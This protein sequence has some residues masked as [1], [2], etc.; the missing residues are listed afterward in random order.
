LGHPVYCRRATFALSQSGTEVR[1]YHPPRNLLEFYMR[2]GAF[3]GNLVAVICIGRNFATKI[4]SN[5]QLQC[6]HVLMIVGPTVLSLLLSNEHAL[7]QVLIIKVISIRALMFFNSKSE[8]GKCI[9]ARNRQYVRHQLKHTLRNLRP[10][11]LKTVCMHFSPAL[12]C[13]CTLQY[14]L[15]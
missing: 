8:V 11:A 12:A 4:E 9:T 6:A 10:H 1:G 7:T 2:F 5:C 13:D 3:R 14:N 15:C